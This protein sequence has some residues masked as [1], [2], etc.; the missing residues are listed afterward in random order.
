MT[1]AQPFI[2]VHY[3]SCIHMVRDVMR[4][5]FGIHKDLP[6][7]E[8]HAALMDRRQEWA[9]VVPAGQPLADG[10]VVLMRPGSPVMHAGVLCLDA[11]EP[12]IL[13]TAE[14]PGVAV[15]Q[16]LRLLRRVMRIE[17]FYRVAA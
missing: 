10:M 15:L 16:P 13:H 14:S 12:H 17:N 3:E 4:I 2:G 9:S 6:A 5:Q 11:P 7:L 8:N 1:W